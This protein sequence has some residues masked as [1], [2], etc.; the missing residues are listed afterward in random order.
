LDTET[1]TDTHRPAY[2]GRSPECPV[3]W[4]FASELIRFGPQSPGTVVP[5]LSESRQ[6]CKHVCNSHYEN[7]SVA[8]W[9]LPRGL[10]PHF[11]AVY[12]YCRWADDLADET[13]GGD[14]AQSL[15][16]WWRDELELAY[17]GT[18]KHPVM[19]ALAETVREFAIPKAPFLDLLT[20]FARDQRVNR[21]ET[22]DELL[23]YCR[24]SANPVGRIVLSL[25]RQF[26]AGRASLSDEICTG[27]QLANFW[28]DVARDLDKGRVY[29]P[30]EDRH[31]FG[32][33]DEDLEERRYTAGF[34]AL[35]KFQVERTRQFFERGRPLLTL[36]PRRPRMNVELFLR[37]GEAVLDGI[38][39]VKYDVWTT[40]PVVTKWQ[41]VKLMGLAM[42]GLGSGERPV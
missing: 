30:A 26:D 13:G 21:Y 11:H 6:Y 8:S 33:T 7:F 23:D 35:M 28:Q 24:N 27:L 39:R 14:A 16:D 36:L 3:P 12:A 10:R 20:A 25:Y 29:L 34:V 42:L 2:T 32:Y 15:L 9:L 40:R 19:I 5:G 37:G 1:V 38:E 4:D 18:P 17:S 41:K 31:R 22:Y